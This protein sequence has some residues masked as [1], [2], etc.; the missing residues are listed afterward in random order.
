MHL[1]AYVLEL[2]EKY[3]RVYTSSGRLC[4]A[5]GKPYEI[6]TPYASNDL[7]NLNYTQYEQTLFLAHPQYPPKQLT[8]VERGVFTFS[9]VPIKYGPFMLANTDASK[10][11][12]VVQSQETQVSTG[13]SATLSFQ[14]F[15]DPTLAV[16]GFFDDVWFFS[17]PDFGL[18][19]ELMVSMF[20]NM[21]SSQGVTAHS[22]G[23]V[24]KIETPTDTGGDWN[25]KQLVLKYYSNFFKDPKLVVTQTLSGGINAGEQAVV[26]E[27]QYQLESDFDCF[28]PGHVGGRFAL[29]HKVPSQYLS[30]LLGYEQSSGFI[31]SSGDWKLRTTGS[32]TG[33]LA[34]E[35]SSDLGETWETAKIFTR[36]TGE[37]NLNTFGQL[38]DENILYCLRLPPSPGGGASRPC[39]A[40]VQLGWRCPELFI[41]V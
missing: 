14:P 26:G 7:R 11:L 39:E 4:T 21:F 8:R 3:L 13:V 1:K 30:G 25:G 17:G 35:V 23:G 31:K 20:N 16:L 2:G 38:E 28:K 15:I 32:W 6:Q 34:L 5:Q 37:E 27:N 36:E 29:T 33:K 41:H 10:Q 22:M 40:C 24:V 12:R 19:I 9:D 18:D